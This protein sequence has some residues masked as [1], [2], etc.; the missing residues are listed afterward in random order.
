[1]PSITEVLEQRAVA[2]IAEVRA[3]CLAVLIERGEDVSEWED[4]EKGERLGDLKARANALKSKPAKP[5]QP[6]AA[7]SSGSKRGR[8]AASDE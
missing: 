2:R 8:R 5:A 4:D 6:P 1:M 3:E 7:A